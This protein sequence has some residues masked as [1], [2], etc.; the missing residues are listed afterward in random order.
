MSLESNLLGQTALLMCE[1]YPT[2]QGL[3]LPWNIGEFS[4]LDAA[5]CSRKSDWILVAAKAAGLI[6]HYSVSVQWHNRLLSFE[7]GP[8]LLTLP[9]LWIGAHDRVPGSLQSI[10]VAMDTL[11]L[12]SCS[13][14]VSERVSE[15][16]DVFVSQIC[17]PKG[18]LYC[19]NQV[20]SE[21]RS[22]WNA[23]ASELR[24]SKCHGA[25][26]IQNLLSLH[27]PPFPPKRKTRRLK[28]V[29]EYYN[30]F[31]SGFVLSVRI[32]YWPSGKSILWTRIYCILE[33]DIM[34]PCRRA[35]GLEKPSSLMTRVDTTEVSGGWKKTCIMRSC[36]SFEPFTK[37]K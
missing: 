37:C 26:S 17:P 3:F 22:N 11:A 23:V 2:C 9:T 10:S 14:W 34:L 5:A 12:S 18:G 20:A 16:V 35:D 27:L 33:C 7:C 36:I 30:Y 31:T 24:N 1:R 29:T 32:G 21:M 13:E 15:C 28:Y 6:R 8:N 25:F 19:T 4:H